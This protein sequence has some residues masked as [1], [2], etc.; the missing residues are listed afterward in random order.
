M[1]FGYFPPPPDCVA[2]NVPPPPE[3]A[4]LEEP[5]VKTNDW[6][7]WFETPGPLPIEDDDE[8]LEPEDFGL[9]DPDDEPLDDPELL[10]SVSLCVQ[11]PSAR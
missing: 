11:T 8:K 10:I 4:E 7:L 9:H 6:L 3:L 2:P 5:V 1:A